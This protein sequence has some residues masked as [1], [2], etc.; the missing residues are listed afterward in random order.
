MIEIENLDANKIGEI[1]IAS[2]FSV[3]GGRRNEAVDPDI[4]MEIIITRF[5]EAQT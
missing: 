1:L 2:Q 5:E 3:D 4:E